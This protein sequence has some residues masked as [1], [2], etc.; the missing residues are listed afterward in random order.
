ME[1]FTKTTSFGFNGCGQ[2]SGFS[3]EK[4]AISLLYTEICS[5]IPSAMLE[6]SKAKGVFVFSLFE[7]QFFFQKHGIGVLVMRFDVC[8]QPADKFFAFPGWVS[9]LG[10]GMGR[11]LF[12]LPLGLGATSEAA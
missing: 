6:C 12:R 1:F 8:H 2:R 4:R 5:V 9:C 3:V 11:W 10:F 7:F